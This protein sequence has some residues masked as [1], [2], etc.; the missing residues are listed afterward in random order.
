MSVAVATIKDVDEHGPII[1]W[2]QHWAEL[3]GRTLYTHLS[4]PAQAV[5]VGAIRE[6]ID[7]LRE[8][9]ETDKQLAARADQLTRAIGTAQE[10]WRDIASAPRDGTAILVST[11]G[12]QIDIATWDG[13]V[14][15]DYAHG[16]P[17]AAIHWM[18]LPT[19]PT[20]GE[21]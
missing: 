9:G 12:R 6:V 17:C 11:F 14:W 8:W 10:G 21:G 4:Q 5:D 1:E 18:P 3:K 19:P 13:A 7:D 20:D 2:H 16:E 15:K